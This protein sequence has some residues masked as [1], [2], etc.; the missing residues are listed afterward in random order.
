[1]TIPVEEDEEPAARGSLLERLRAVI[2]A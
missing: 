1:V 2:A